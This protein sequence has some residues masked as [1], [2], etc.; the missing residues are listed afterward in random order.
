ML[1]VGLV[2]MLF[3]VTIADLTWWLW[4]AMLLW[5]DVFLQSALTLSLVWIYRLDATRD[6]ASGKPSKVGGKNLL[7]FCFSLLLVCFEIQVL[8]R[9]VFIHNNGA[10]ELRS[11]P[12]CGRLVESFSS[13]VSRRF[14]PSLC[15]G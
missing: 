4:G 8:L 10:F 6:P 12:V 11:A 9:R 13:L 14:S 5:T 7:S 1:L 3:S 15:S 2:S